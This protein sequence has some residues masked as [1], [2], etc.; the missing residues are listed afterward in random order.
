MGNALNSQTGQV[1]S[2]GE[3]LTP[4]NMKELIFQP[5]GLLGWALSLV[6]TLMFPWKLLLG[7]SMLKRKGKRAQVS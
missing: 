1:F 2:H 5:L 6:L 3:C 7:E 4:V